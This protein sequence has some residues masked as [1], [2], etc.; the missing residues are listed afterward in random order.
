[1]PSYT[2][3]YT[4]S[5]ASKGDDSYQNIILDLL[6]RWKSG[7]INC[8]GIMAFLKSQGCD[9]DGLTDEEINNEANRE[10]RT[11]VAEATQ[12][13]FED[14]DSDSEESTQ[15]AAPDEELQKAFVVAIQCIELPCKEHCSN[16]MDVI[17]DLMDMWP[18]GDVDA[19]GTLA[20]L[21]EN[22]HD[23]G[24]LDDDVS[25]STDTALLRRASEAL[26]EVCSSGGEDVQK[27]YIAALKYIKVVEG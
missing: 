17:R 25:E 4:G 6:E 18:E 13:I 2:I 20:F 10:M 15:P 3:V 26:I 27:A 9:F 1:M 8:Y 23:I 12:A 14:S 7:E 19:H 22:G 24:L 21:K 11:A 5:L 16:L